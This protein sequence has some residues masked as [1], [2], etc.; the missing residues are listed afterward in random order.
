[1]F[2]GLCGLGKTRNVSRMVRA[3]TREIHKF[4]DS[5]REASP[6]LV[7]GSGE[8]K[9]MD[10][11]ARSTTAPWLGRD[12][13]DTRA[14]KHMIGVTAAIHSR[15]SRKLSTYIRGALL[16][17]RAQQHTVLRVQEVELNKKTSASLL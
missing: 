10:R 16:F 13:M 17:R 4:A 3:P 7:F 8:K 11:A 12:E 15:Q 14:V 6:D 2:V 1:M 5:A 9:G